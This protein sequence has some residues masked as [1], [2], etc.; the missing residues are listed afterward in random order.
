MP[1]TQPI[2]LCLFPD[3]IKKGLPEIIREAVKK[4][5]RDYV[6]KIEERMDGEF[7]YIDILCP[8]SDYAIAYYMLGREVGSVMYK[9]ERPDNLRG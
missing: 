5:N 4:L 7:L 1:N 6:L 2:H 8:L 9:E 3:H